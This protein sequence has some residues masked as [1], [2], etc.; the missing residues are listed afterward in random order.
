MPSILTLVAQFGQ[1]VPAFIYPWIKYKK[2]NVFKNKIVIYAKLIA[3]AGLLILLLFIWNKTI[4]I[5]NENRAIGLYF[6]NF[7]FSLFG[8]F[9]FYFY[10]IKIYIKIKNVRFLFFQFLLQFLSVKLVNVN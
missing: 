7:C 3:E 6:V 1:I 9:L 4:R 2:P 10:K 8:L 5:A